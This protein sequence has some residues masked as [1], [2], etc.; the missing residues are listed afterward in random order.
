VPHS[1]YLGANVV[2]K[3]RVFMP[4]AGGMTRYRAICDDVVSKNYNGFIFTVAGIKSGGK[5]NSEDRFSAAH[6]ISSPGI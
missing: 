1:W 4:Y 6:T 2:G 5:D 3:P